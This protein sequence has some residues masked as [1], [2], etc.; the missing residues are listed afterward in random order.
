MRT[1]RDVEAYLA[2]SGR[3][4]EAVKDR[5]GVYLVDGA[6]GIQTAVRIDSQLVVARVHIGEVP[7]G[8]TAPLLRK[9]LEHNAG[10]LVHTSFGLDGNTIVLTAALSLEN[11]DRNE[12][13]AVLDEIDMSLTRD[14]PSLRTLTASIPPPPASAGAPHTPRE[15]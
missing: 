15:Q 1:E 6:H 5:P 3:R 13:E 7:P 10:T 12:L 4:Y 9:L 8:E 14:V 11:I 2:A